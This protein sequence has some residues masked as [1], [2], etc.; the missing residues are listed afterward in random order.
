MIDIRT[1]R[2]NPALVEQSIRDRHYPEDSFVILFK[3]VQL[4]GQWRGIKKEEEQLRAERNKLSME[5]NAKK[6]AGEAAE[7]E[8]VRSGEV[9]KRIK[10]ISVETTTLEEQISALALLLPN[11]PH[12]SVQIGKDETANPEIRKWGEPKKFSKD[13]PSH[14][15]LAQKSG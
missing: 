10:D 2:E 11:I 6:K 7:N 4:D 15:D 1:L 5:I 13:V 3:I 9:S 8:I 12:N 14:Y